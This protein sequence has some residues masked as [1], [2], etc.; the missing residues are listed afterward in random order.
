MAWLYVVSTNNA[1]T[2]YNAVRLANVS[3]NKGKEVNLFMLG[4]GV[5][6]ND[7]S[8]EEFDVNGQIEE[9]Y[10]KGGELIV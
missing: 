2:V 10:G 4:K 7:I 6:F 9:F 3:L 5:E 8:S 1:E